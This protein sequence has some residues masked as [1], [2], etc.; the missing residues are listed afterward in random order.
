[1]QFK[2]V[3]FRAWDT[4]CKK[5]HGLGGLQDI[6]SLRCDGFTNDVYILSQFTGL[7]D[8]HG[9]HIYEGDL[10][11]SRYNDMLLVVVWDQGTC[12]YDLQDSI[13]N[14]TYGEHLLDLS[15]ECD[16]GENIWEIK[17]NIFQ[18]PELLVKLRDKHV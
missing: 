9:I 2:Q 7:K 11:K 6:F 1:M 12:S 8:K 18:N 13:D 15:G 16:L 17:G 5:F 10:L 4:I 3:K 14:P